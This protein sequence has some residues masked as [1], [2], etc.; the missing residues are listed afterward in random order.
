MATLLKILQDPKFDAKKA[1]KSMQV[2][3]KI[4]TKIAAQTPLKAFSI[5]V[6]PIFSLSVRARLNDSFLVLD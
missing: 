3:N 6:G 1:P 4:S 2:F 5:E